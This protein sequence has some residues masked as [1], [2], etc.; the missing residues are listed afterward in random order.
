MGAG[1]RFAEPQSGRQAG[2]QRL[3]EHAG[4][5][6]DGREPTRLVN[7]P[8]NSGEFE[9]GEQRDRQPPGTQRPEG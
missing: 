9:P 8:S 6:A 3:A 2:D 7:G 1:A 4:R 5:S